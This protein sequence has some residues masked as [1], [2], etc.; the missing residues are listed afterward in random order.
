MVPVVPV[1][2]PDDSPF[3][4]PPLVDSGS[5]EL[6]PVLVVGVEVKLVPEVENVVELVAAPVDES[7]LPDGATFVQAAAKRAHP[8]VA[9]ENVI[10]ISSSWAI[11]NWPLANHRP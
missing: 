6:G 11:S 10:M 2:R 8:I 3:D 7:L 1:S 4:E 5:V 9:R